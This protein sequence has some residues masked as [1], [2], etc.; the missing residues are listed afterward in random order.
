[1]TTRSIDP[2][3]STAFNAACVKR[4]R[5]VP[6]LLGIGLLC[7]AAGDLV[8]TIQSLGGATPPS[9]SLADGFYIAFYPV[10]YVAL[11][12]DTL[13]GRGSPGSARAL[14]LLREVFEKRVVARKA[15]NDGHRLSASPCLLHAQLSDGTIRYCLLR[16]LAASAPALGQTA[17]RAHP[18][19]GGRVDQAAVAAHPF[20]VPLTVHSR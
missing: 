4:R 17:F 13:V 11:Q 6:I 19:R 9:P 8:L 16:S 18:A 12:F 1:M 7:W 14:Q 20:I 2:G 5:A 3:V 10:T 15:V